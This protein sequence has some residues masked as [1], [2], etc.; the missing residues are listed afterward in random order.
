MLRRSSG[1]SSIEAAA[2]FSSR[3]LQLGGAGDR[4][5]PW[6]LRQQPGQRDLR[7]RRALLL[8]DLF[9]QVDQGRF[10]LRASGVNRGKVVRLSLL[11][12]VV[13]SSI[14]PVRKPLPSGLKGTKPIPS[15]SQA[16]STS[17][18]G[19]APPEGV[20]ALDGRDRLD[21]VRAADGLGPLARLD[22]K[23][24]TLPSAMRSFTAPATS[25]IG[26]SGSTRCW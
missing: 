24:L 18:S 4:H 9:Q 17:A 20:F 22:P 1:V 15:S 11:P 2:M 6:L 3:R 12:N 5:D 16:G 21:R 14:L 25:S 7:R 19:L 23:C 10:A 13:V 26:T 8:A